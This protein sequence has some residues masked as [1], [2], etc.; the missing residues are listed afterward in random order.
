MTEIRKHYRMVTTV[1]RRHDLVDPFFVGKFGFSPYHA[2]AHGCLYCDGRAERYWVD[3]EFEKDIVVRANAP[4]VLD[5]ELGK[6]RERGIVFIGSG[7]SDA[8]QPPEADEGLMRDCACVLLARSMPVTILTKSSLI[9]RDI[10]TW[11]GVNQK[12]GFMLMMS[13]NTVDDRIRGIFEPRASTIGERLHTLGT[14]RERGCSVG[15]AAMPLLPFLSDSEADLDVLAQKLAEI[16]VQFVLWGGLTLRP[17]RQKELFFKTLRD[18]FPELVS[19]YEHLFAENRVSGAPLSEYSRGLHWHAT[20]AF[21]RAGMPTLVPHRLFRNRLPIYDEIYVL[22][23]HMLLIY[24]GHTEPVRRLRASLD[25]Y[26]DWLRERKKAL[27]RTRKL[28]GSHL[29][30]DL[31]TMAE[32]GALARLLDNE[33][34][35]GFLRGVIL[36]RR[37]FDE[38]HRVLT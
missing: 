16:G 27:N 11:Q 7:V 29:E 34:L 3:G 20:A 25:R 26:R 37:I 35:A 12:G 18:S 10:D 13:L 17:G 23:H 22:L 4:G 30:G 36:D 21:A 2:C 38:R 15:V 24:A 19:R 32:S 1:L 33:K 6:L 8:Y 28:L 9:L 14:F 31:I 5:A